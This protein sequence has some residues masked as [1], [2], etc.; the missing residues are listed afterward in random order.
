MAFTTLENRAFHLYIIDKNGENLKL[1]SKG[2]RFCGNPVFSPDQSKVV[3]VKNDKLVSHKADIYL[4]DI[5]GNNEIKL[6]NQNSNSSPIWNVT[7]TKI[8]YTSS[9]DTSCGVY[10]MNL[11][12]SNK[13][14]LTPNNLCLCRPKLSPDGNKLSL[15]S[16]DWNGSQIFVMDLSSKEVKQITFTVNPHHFDSGFPVE[17]NAN[18]AWS[19]N[20]DKLAYV[21]WEYGNP[22]IFIISADGTGN[23][24]L[25]NT[26]KSRE[27]NPS[28]SHDGQF[29]VFSSMRNE[30]AQAEI[31][32]M[33]A[34][35]TNQKA[36]T[37]YKGDDT[38]PLWLK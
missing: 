19:P 1:L 13:T 32:V 7:G 3:F 8:L 34:D 5:D 9:T 15:V 27:E 30:K 17:G 24:R 10:S 6:T 21:S 38:Y 22:E 14:L 2:L 35:G 18:P 31:F 36:L 37:N 16:N 28:W 23:K 12:G 33:N 4:I 29:I 20:S 25:T 11:D 26:T